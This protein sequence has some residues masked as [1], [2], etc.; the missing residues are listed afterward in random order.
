VTIL[1][2]SLVVDIDDTLV[3]TAFRR[4]NVWRSILEREIPFGEVERLGSRQILKR[5][6]FGDQDIWFRYWSILLCWESVGPEFLKLD[7]PISYASQLLKKW[8]E[9]YKVVYLTGRS[10]NMEDITLAQLEAMDLPTKGIALMMFTK[11]D[12]EKYL[13]SKTSLLKLR[14]RLFSVLSKRYEIERVIDDYPSNFSI[15]KRFRILDR[16]GLLRKKRFSEQDYLNQGA[17][18]VS[19]WRQLWKENITSI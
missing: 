13:S 8:S 10:R 2:L 12:W 7:K 11:R 14:N 17:T 15:Y 6:A 18:R 5:Y 1:I 9:E 19:S 4:W 16:I 3:N